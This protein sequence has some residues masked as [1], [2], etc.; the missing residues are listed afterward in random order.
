MFFILAVYKSNDVPTIGSLLRLEKFD[1]LSSAETR[2][3]EL[4]GLGVPVGPCILV[5]DEIT[6]DGEV[7]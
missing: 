3:S 2:R 7:A 6:D 4:V 5:C 1:S